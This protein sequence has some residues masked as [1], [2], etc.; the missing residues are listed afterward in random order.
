[1][2]RV[3]TGWTPEA[4]MLPGNHSS[5]ALNERGPALK[6]FWSRPWRDGRR[7]GERALATTS[8]RAYR[9][10]DQENRAG[11]SRAGH[12]PSAPFGSKVPSTKAHLREGTRRALQLADDRHSKL[13]SCGG[14][15]GHL[16][17]GFPSAGY[18]VFTPYRIEIRL[19]TLNA[20]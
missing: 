13:R 7:V 2:P 10:V 12:V 1:V 9:T 6:V 14:P 8:T 18:G 17:S 19:A 20:L 11:G 15:R 5:L 3:T 4:A 16:V